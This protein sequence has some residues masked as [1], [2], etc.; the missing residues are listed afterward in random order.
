MEPPTFSVPSRYCKPFLVAG[1][2]GLDVA[3]AL[4]LREAQQEMGPREQSPELGWQAS[5]AFWE[6]KETES[7]PVQW[8]ICLA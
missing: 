4:H 3:G 6:V 7:Q 8:A 1:Y 2:L 5:E